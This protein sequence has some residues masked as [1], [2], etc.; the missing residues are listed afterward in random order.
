MSKGPEQMRVS[1]QSIE[2][3]GP[4]Y[5][6]DGHIMSLREMQTKLTT[7]HHSIPTATTAIFLKR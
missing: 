2:T 6:K 5:V 7:R 1:P 3:N 4:Q